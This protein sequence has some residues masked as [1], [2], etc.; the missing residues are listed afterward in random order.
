M[1]KF[2]LLLALF[3]FNCSKEH[4]HPIQGPIVEAVYGL[5]T[6]DSEEVYHAKSAILTSVQEFY[7]Q[8]GSDVKKGD[9]L[10]RND[11]NN[12]LRSPINGR[13]IS[14]GPSLGEVVFPQTQILTI[15]NLETL[16]L[17][18]SLEQQGTMRMKKDMN[19]EISFDFYR[20]QKIKG[21]VVSIFPQENQFLTKV[22]VEK[23]PPGVLPGMTADVAF[24]IARKE[25]ATLVPISAVANGHLSIIRDDKKQ[26]LPIEIGLMDE[27][28]VEV[29]SPKLNITDEVLVP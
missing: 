8:E 29:I 17:S 5:G 7:V 6:I 16:Y 20:D 12:V 28:F 13:V 15:I 26:K 19:C 27:K 11:Q 2:L 10:F 14:I 21:K 18:V 25:L 23:W 24:E 1:K 3:L 9:K 22:T 4:I